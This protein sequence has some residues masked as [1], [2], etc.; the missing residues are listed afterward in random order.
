MASSRNMVRDSL[1]QNL[2][3]IDLSELRDPVGI[4]ELAELVT[5]STYEQQFYFQSEKT[6]RRSHVRENN[7]ATPRSVKKEGEEVLQV[8]KLRFLCKP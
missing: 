4:F 6:R 5:K 2:D 7:R 1:A 8:L 3:E